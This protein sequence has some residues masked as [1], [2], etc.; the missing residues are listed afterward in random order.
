MK[1]RNFVYLAFLILG[2]C[3]AREPE[4][5]PPTP[6]PDSVVWN[7]DP[8]LA[9]VL[10]RSAFGQREREAAERVEVY[11]GPVQFID[12]LG[13]IAED[14]QVPWVVRI[15]AL[16]LLADRGAAKELPA[17]VAALDPANEERLR[18]A[19]VSGM[20]P[21]LLSQPQAAVDI[22]KIALRDPSPR[23]QARALEMLADRDPDV[24][25]EYVGYTRNDELR[26]V[27]RSLIRV[28]EERG[29]GAIPIDSTGV[30]QRT[31]AEGVTITFRPTTNWQEWDA[32]IGNL[33]VQQPGQQ[34][35]LVADS[36]EVVAGV[37][38]AF[39]ATDTALLVYEVNREIHVHSLLDHSDKKIADGIAPR[40]MPVNNNVIYFREIPRRRT[41]TPNS[42]GYKYEVVM[43][44]LEGGDPEVLGEVG[45]LAQNAVHGNYSSIRWVRL[46]EE[47]GRFFLKGDQFEEF[48]L[49]SPFG[50]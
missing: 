7:A 32:A 9:P 28:A 36:V 17:F 42:V 6:V 29:A 21:F 16:T 33:Y 13:A 4:L 2:A 45:A 20:R 39:L 12:R 23:V 40:L 22:L 18:V 44:P 38:P 49:P 43:Q 11:V 35:V 3:S 34:P 37:V 27:A 46:R 25:R 14:P 41:E 50:G 48:L 1:N 5:A 10:R 24:L 15:N 26:G 47:E 19:A 31:S 30:Y 8:E